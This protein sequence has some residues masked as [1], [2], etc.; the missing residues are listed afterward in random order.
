MRNQLAVSFH[1]KAFRIH[2]KILTEMNIQEI[3]LKLA[4]EDAKEAAEGINPP[5][6]AS[7]TSFLTKAFD[8]EEQQ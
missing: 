6:K 2:S 7:L 5:H 1:A 4:K 3:R 8:L